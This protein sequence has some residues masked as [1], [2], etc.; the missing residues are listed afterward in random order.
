MRNG[1]F[2]SGFFFGML[3]LLSISSQAQWAP[4]QPYGEAVNALAI[5]D[6]I[7][8]AG[9]DSN[10]IILS[11]DS[12]ISWSA[13]NS[14][15]NNFTIHAL[16]FISSAIFAGT[17]AWVFRS[18]DNGSTWTSLNPLLSDYTVYEFAV[19]SRPLKRLMKACFYGKIK[20][21]DITS[22]IPAPSRTRPTFS[23]Q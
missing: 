18:T 4:N 15:I 3:F 14:G 6:S 7:I 21:V 16:A 10:G 2:S 9:T 1:L 11:T 19:A 13:I 12:G 20:W 5:N 23:R 17:D 22:T 8:F